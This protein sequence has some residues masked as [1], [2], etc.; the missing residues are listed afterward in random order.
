MQ[1]ITAHGTG[2][3]SS[4]SPT[5]LGFFPGGP[6]ISPL[7]QQGTGAGGIPRQ[8]TGQASA[9]QQSGIPHPAITANLTGSALGSMA[10]SGAKAWDVSPTDKA[11]F[12]QFF[13]TLDTQKRAFIEGDVA[14][15]FMLQSKLSEDV[16]AQIW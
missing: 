12:D 14:V 5:H 13:D 6:S 16:L 2:A 4:S 11:K 9:F 3:S 15:P 1:S 7:V 10:F 8:T